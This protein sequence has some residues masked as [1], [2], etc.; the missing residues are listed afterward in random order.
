MSNQHMKFSNVYPMLT[1]VLSFWISLAPVSP[2]G[3]QGTCWTRPP[4]TSWRNSILPWYGWMIGPKTGCKIDSTG[5]HVVFFSIY[6][7]FNL[8]SS[9]EPSHIGYFFGNI[10]HSNDKPP[11]QT[12][13]FQYFHFHCFRMFLYRNYFVHTER[14]DI[15]ENRKMILEAAR[16]SLPI[17]IFFDK[18]IPAWFA[19]S[20]FSAHSHSLLSSSNRIV[21]LNRYCRL[22]H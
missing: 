21:M 7:T 11:L 22:A 19:K 8:K 1:N 5:H 14:I 9:L 4:N 12:L 2:T 18:I 15:S 10:C 16:W 20:D 13:C 17:L 3:Q 6:T